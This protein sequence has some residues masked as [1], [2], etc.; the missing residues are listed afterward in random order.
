MAAKL[1]DRVKVDDTLCII[2]S[3]KMMNHIKADRAGTVEAILVA[4]EVAV[5]FDQPLFTLI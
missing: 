2:E 3:M 1:G 5:E 4:N